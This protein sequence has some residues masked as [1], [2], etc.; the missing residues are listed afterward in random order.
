MK[1]EKSYWVSNDN[2]PSMAKN[3]RKKLKFKDPDNPTNSPARTTVISEPDMYFQF[4]ATSL[5]ADV[6]QMTVPYFDAQPVVPQPA[7]WTTELNVFLRGRKRFAGF[8][9]LELYNY[10]ITDHYVNVE[11][12][13]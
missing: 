8:I 5:D 6:S 4:Q 7:S 10:N 12:N 2:T 13:F 1:P 9:S 3:P 11:N